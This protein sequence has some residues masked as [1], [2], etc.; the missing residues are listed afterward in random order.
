[1]TTWRYFRDHTGKQWRR[2]NPWGYGTIWFASPMGDP[3][4]CVAAQ[5]VAAV[6]EAANGWRAD[7]PE[8][9]SVVTRRE[10]LP[11]GW[12]LER[13]SIRRRHI[14]GGE[15]INGH[16][17]HAVEVYWRFALRDSSGATLPVGRVYQ[18]KQVALI[19]QRRQG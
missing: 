9:S 2:W 10:L 4:R 3:G 7:W 17:K 15:G 16:H 19:P 11:G 18:S 14:V 6:I 13:H 1:M 8:D 5:G 12:C